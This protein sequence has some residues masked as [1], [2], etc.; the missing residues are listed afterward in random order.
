MCEGYF[1]QET[2]GYDHEFDA[3]DEQQAIIIGEDLLHNKFDHCDTGCAPS[4]NVKS[5]CRTSTILICL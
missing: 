4:S 5:M 2:A 3:D 1:A